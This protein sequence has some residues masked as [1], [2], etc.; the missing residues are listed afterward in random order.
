MNENNTK[1]LH[2]F[3]ANGKNTH[4]S[5]NHAPNGMAH[6][7]GGYVRIAEPTRGEWRNDIAIGMCDGAS[8]RMTWVW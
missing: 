8:V 3:A 1:P 7:K 6:G 2:L 4:R 5:K